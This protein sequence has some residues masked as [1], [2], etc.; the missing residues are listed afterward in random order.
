[1][2]KVLGH[3]I[4]LG[5]SAAGLMAARVLADH[6]ERVTVIERDELPDAAEHRKGTPQS[7]HANNLMAGAVALLERWYPGATDEFRARGATVERGDTMRFWLEGRR[8]AVTDVGGATLLMTR[9][10]LDEVLRRRLRDRSEVTVLT[11]RDVVGLR[12][13]GGR[14]AGADT[15]RRSDRTREAH[16]ADLVVDAMGRGS[17]GTA[18]L[19]SAGFAPPDEVRIDVG[20]RYAT[21]LFE[22]RAG[23]LDGDQSVFVAPLGRARGGVAFAVED[24]RWLVTLYGYR[25]DAP[26][27]D[28]DAFRAWTATLPSDE[29]AR[30]VAAARPLDDGA[31]FGV[32]AVRLRRFDRLP[33]PPRGWLAIGDSLCNLN[34]CYGQGITS[35]AFQVEA[36]DDAL[37][38]G[39]GGLE[40]RYYRRAVARASDLF[41]LGWGNDAGLDGYDGPR[42]PVPAP[43][44]W[45]LRRLQRVAAY[46]ATVCRAFQRVVTSLGGRTS[47]FAPRVVWRVL[48]AR[49]ESPH[50][51]AGRALRATYGDR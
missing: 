50:A 19:E 47:V 41:E 15:E 43:L 51:N 1:M 22:R 33:R 45:Y 13:A 8:L 37:A 6:A 18:W 3:A 5:G 23:D 26:P 29:I 14:V 36:L 39:R 20:V 46:D 9:P 32:P 16:D 30:L 38:E 25:G 24:G 28:L 2:A 21:R 10:V 48:A 40:R 44:R 17:K 27:A 31:T 4:V 12:H 11:G 42:S 7:R 35:A 34:P 49:E